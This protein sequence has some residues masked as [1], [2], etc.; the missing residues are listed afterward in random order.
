[1]DQLQFSLVQERVAEIAL[2]SDGLQRLALDYQSRTPYH[3]F[4][5][6]LFSPLRRASRE[7][8]PAL[9]SHLANYLNSTRIND[10]TDDD[11]TLVLA[12]SQGEAHHPEGK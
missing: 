2:L 4:F 1:M 11:K 7:S 6:G 10:R 8:L 9:N 3:P 12:T 5:S